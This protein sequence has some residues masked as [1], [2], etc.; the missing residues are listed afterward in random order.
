MAERTIAAIAT[1][2]GE[3]SVGIIRISGAEAFLI[4]DK[5]F[6]S[7]SGKKIADISGYSALFGEIRNGEKRLDEAVALKFVAP[8]SYTGEDVVELSVHGGTLLI[9]EALR[10]VL[11]AGAVLAQAGEFTKR[12][13]LNG[14]MDLVKAE[15]V[16]GLISASNTSELRISQSVHAGGTS[17]QLS[18]IEKNLVSAAASIAAYCDYPE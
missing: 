2:L 1:P 5:V 11:N 6:F 12:A 3:G 4:A 15:S 17:K 8:K 13:F 9:K 14:K 10:A 16:M 7:V 18:A